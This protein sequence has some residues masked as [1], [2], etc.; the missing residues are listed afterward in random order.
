MLPARRSTCSV[1]RHRAPSVLR[2]RLGRVLAVT[3]LAFGGT[4]VIADPAHASVSHDLRHKVINVAAAQAGDPYVWGAAGP[5]AFDCSGF[6][7]YA[8]GKIGKYLPHKASSQVAYTT[9]VAA[10][11]RSH[12]DLVFFYNSYGS[13]Y[14]VG[15]YAGDGYIWYAPRTGDVVKKGKIWSSNVFYGGVK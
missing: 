8:Y 6:T 1:G 12:G 2:P 10:A 5:D 4:T 13:V 11:N 15:I 14:H 9:R 3:A 7:K